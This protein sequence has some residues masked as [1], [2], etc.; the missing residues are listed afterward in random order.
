MGYDEEV[1]AG[2]N[3]KH[4]NACGIDYLDECP[5]C[6][7]R[8]LYH[9]EVGIP[10]GPDDFTFEDCSCGCNDFWDKYEAIRHAKELSGKNDII[11]R[12]VDDN[13]KEIYAN[14]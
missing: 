14:A 3:W 6:N 11:V 8:T 5:S 2:Q 13:G 12:V 4:C 7:H 1:R 10:D 9:V